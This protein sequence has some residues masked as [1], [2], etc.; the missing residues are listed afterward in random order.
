MIVAWRNQPDV[1]AGFIEYEPL[2]TEGQ[3]RF[4]ERLAGDP[5]RKLWMITLRQGDAVHP[6]G[7]AAGSLAVGMVGLIDIDLRNRRCELGPIFIGSPEH[8]GKGLAGRAE[9]IVLRHC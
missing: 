9:V 2:S 6:A 1:H 8:R 4:M 5:T 7:A 3:R